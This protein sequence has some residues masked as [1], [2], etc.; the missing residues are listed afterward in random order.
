VNRFPVERDGETGCV[1]KAVSIQARSLLIDGAR[2]L[3]MAPTGRH[4]A[5]PHRRGTARAGPDLVSG[6]F[7]WRYCRDV[8]YFNY[9]WRSR[10]NHGGRQRLTPA[11]QAGI[12]QE[13]WTMERLYDEVMA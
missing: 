3:S 2:T 5:W 10:E 6:T 11:M 9:C 12:T 1:E 4:Y 7:A 8:A 13:L